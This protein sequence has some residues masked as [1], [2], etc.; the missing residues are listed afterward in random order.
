MPVSPAHV[1]GWVASL[2]PRCCC[3]SC[4]A[5]H[6]TCSLR[7]R[8]SGCAFLLQA[9]GIACAPAWAPVPANPLQEPCRAASPTRPETR[10]PAPPLWRPRTTGSG[11]CRRPRHRGAVARPLSASSP[12]TPAAVPPLPPDGPCPHCHTVPEGRSRGDTREHRAS[13]FRRGATLTTC[14]RPPVADDERRTIGRARPSQWP[15]NQPLPSSKVHLL[16]LRLVVARSGAEDSPSSPTIPSARRVSSPG[17][18]ARPPASPQHTKHTPPPPAPSRERRAATAASAGT[19]A[20]LPT[21]PPYFH[22]GDRGSTRPPAQG[23]RVSS[24]PS[25]SLVLFLQELLYFIRL[26]YRA[27]LCGAACRGVSRVVPGLAP[28]SPPRSRCGLP[29]EPRRDIRLRPVH[30]RA[31]RC[32]PDHRLPPPRQPTRRRVTAVVECAS[33]RRGLASAAWFASAVLLPPSG[34]LFSFAGFVRRRCATWRRRESS[35]LRLRCDPVL[36][37]EPRSAHTRGACRTARLRVRG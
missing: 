9:T 22:Q 31:C 1:E 35:R 16:P 15:T 14:A 34:R 10:R 27:T 26:P 17:G 8:S 4:S 13:R 23:R 30:L 36:R 28:P 5:Y 37:E 6:A 18:R 3:G 2:D 29:L 19:A 11:R 24:S 12:S 33:K 7:R 25:S 32:R 21:H 20:P